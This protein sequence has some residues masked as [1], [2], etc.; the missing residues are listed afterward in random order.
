MIRQIFGKRDPGSAQAGSGDGQEPPSSEPVESPFGEDIT[1]P[2]SRTI[3]SHF[4]G[5]WVRDMREC[6]NVGSSSREIIAAGQ[7]VIGDKAER[8]VAVRFIS[9]SQIAVVTRP[10]DEEHGAYTLHHR[11]VSQDGQE[12]V[13]LENMDWVLRRCPL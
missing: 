4:H 12:L 9:P 13:D 7:M 10:A 1:N 6:R 2:D 11:G 3:P 5:E 8:V